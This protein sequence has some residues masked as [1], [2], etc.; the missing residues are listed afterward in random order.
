EKRESSATGGEAGSRDKE[1]DLPG[2]L[3]KDLIYQ[4]DVEGATN[5]DS[6]NHYHRI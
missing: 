1:S 2:P 4:N 6:L 5:L 3:N